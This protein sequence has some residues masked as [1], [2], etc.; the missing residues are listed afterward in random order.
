MDEFYVNNENI[1]QEEFR[2]MNIRDK[3][4]NYAAGYETPAGQSSADSLEK[5]MSVISQRQIDARLFE[6]ET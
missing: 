5:L 6:V 1:N 2:K 4:L 3:I